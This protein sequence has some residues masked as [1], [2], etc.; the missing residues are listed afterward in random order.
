MWDRMMEDR[1]RG[2][3]NASN[4]DR[5][6]LPPAG[7]DRTAGALKPDGARGRKA[8]AHDK[9]YPRDAVARVVRAWRGRYDGPQRVSIRSLA[10]PEFSSNAVR[11]V[12]R[13]DE[14]GAFQ[15]GPRGGLMCVGIDKQ[16]RHSG[17]KISLREL[18]R[19][20]GLEPLS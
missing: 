8:G 3:E 4:A 16:F 6:G 1:V 18:E 13:L 12:K 9:L 10:R 19:I 7:A 15:L 5:E 11:R 17:P 20:L 2:F 14:A